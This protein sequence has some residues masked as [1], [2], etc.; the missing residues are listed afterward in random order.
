MKVNDAK[1]SPIEIGAI[2]VWK[3]VD[4][5]KA[6]FGV[7]N[8][9]SFVSTQ[10]DTAIRSTA[11][12]YP[13]DAPDG[14]DS[15]RGSPEI[16]THSL[17]EKLSERLK[18]AGI[19]VIEARLS[20]LA[21]APEIAGSMLK[22]QQAEATIEARKYIIENAVQMVEDVL[23]H[24]KNNKTIENIDDNQKAMLINNLLVALVSERD[25]QPVIPMNNRV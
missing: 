21:Y 9:K 18:I 17:I 11:S 10:C 22:R 23:R 13:Y 16:I 4:P 8:Y 14:V 20:H 15:L 25:I 1:G 24:L 6:H 19:E 5:Y 2:V 7:E 12:D 3:V